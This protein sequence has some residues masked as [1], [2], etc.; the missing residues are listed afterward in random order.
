MPKIIY[1]SLIPFK[2]FYAINLFGIVFVRKGLSSIS[3]P[4]LNHESIHTA[5]MRDY[6]YIGFYI[7]YLLEWIKHLFKYKF[8]NYDA[9]HAISFEKEAYAN[10]YNYNYLETRPKYNHKQ[11]K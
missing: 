7:L 8:N 4:T 2:G 5:Q 9:Y 10:Q 6:W 3:K 11:Y 1:N